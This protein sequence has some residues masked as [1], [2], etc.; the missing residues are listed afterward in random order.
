METKEKDWIEL[1]EEIDFNDSVI[2]PEDK[3][4][5]EIIELN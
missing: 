3:K 1:I 2:S 5:E 4:L